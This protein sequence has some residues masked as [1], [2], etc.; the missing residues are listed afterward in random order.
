MDLL[1]G[2]KQ[3]A[4]SFDLFTIKEITKHKRKENESC[5]PFVGHIKRLY[6]LDK[7]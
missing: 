1:H 4:Y 6:L 3:Q 5:L 7:L 2:L